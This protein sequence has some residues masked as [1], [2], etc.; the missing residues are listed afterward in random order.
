MLSEM[1]SI[2]GGFL[3][4]PQPSVP[5]PNVSVVS[6]LERAVGVGNRV[7]NEMR[8]SLIVAAIKGSRLEA[9]VRFQIW[10]TQPDDV[11]SAIQTLH[12]NLLTAKSTLR[13]QGFLRLDAIATSLAEFDA[14]LNQWSKTCDYKVLYEFQ[15]QDTEGAESLIAR[16]PITVN[17]E[18]NESTLVTDHMA[19]WDNQTAPILQLRGR[20]TLTR[21][22]ALAY[23]P[24]PLPSGSV[25]LTRTFDSATGPPTIY[26]TLTD[27]LSAIAG[28]NPATRHGQISFAS[29]SAF[30]DAFRS[31]GT[32]VALGD[33]DSDGT[34]DL[35]QSRLLDFSPPIQLATLRDRFE[36]APQNNPLN[37]VAVVYLQAS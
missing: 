35:Y 16:I 15:F 31:E 29:L 14:A 8:G 7:G 30:L 4:S 33:W 9:V 18:Y 6:V 21:L 22:S 36:I 23:L 32:P 28:S 26:P 5:G 34:P 2:L 37:Q 3:P 20:A 17:G 12:E 25:T 13:G 19:R 24:F 11:N 1:L 27:F 10:A